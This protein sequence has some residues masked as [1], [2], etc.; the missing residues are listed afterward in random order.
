MTKSRS[1]LLAASS[2]V[3]AAALT[4]CALGG[5]KPKHFG[6]LAENSNIGVAMRAHVALQKGDVASAVSYAERAVEKSP[7]DAAFR[8]LLGN[9]YLAAGRFRSAEAA[10]ADALAIYPNQVGVPLKLALAQVAQGRDEAAAQ[11]LDT[12]AQVISPADGGLALALAGRPGAAIETLEQ[13]ARSDGAD[14]RVRQ[15]LALAHAIAG[16]WTRARRVAEQDLS[17]DQLEQRMSEW[18]TFARPGVAATQVASLIGLK[19]AP[20]SDSGMPVRLALRSKN[21]RSAEASVA[22]PVAEAPVLAAAEP[23]PVPVIEQEQQPVAV[24]AAEVPQPYTAVQYAAT[25]P[26]VAAMVDSLRAERIRPS[27]V[28]PKVAELR[29]AAAKRFGMS[30]AV[31]QLG[32]YATQAG[33]KAGWATIARR[34]RGVTA[35]V[36]ASARFADAR[37]SVYRL[38]LK[39]FASDGEARRLCMQLK[40]SGATC[41]VRNAA[42]DAPVRFAGR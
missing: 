9:A 39:G 7:T 2:I 24:A 34:H 20:A 41:F 40:S 5:G 30:Q 33:V 32:A 15:N 26:D 38:S 19:V 3:A 23:V 18:A 16:D 12:Y 35:Y 21:V 31:V 6:G 25:S 11:T 42:G 29:R 1:A 14:S 4:G 37:G 13:A 22:A 36:P 8:A 10:F 17:G 27:G 28:L